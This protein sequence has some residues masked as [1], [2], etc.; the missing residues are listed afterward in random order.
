[1]MP[2][3]STI[4]RLQIQIMLPVTA[5]KITVIDSLKSPN[6]VPRACAL[7]SPSSLLLGFTLYQ[8][9][10][11]YQYW[12]FAHYSDLLWTDPAVQDS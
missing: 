4:T 6:I 2:F 1:M 12:L 5:T 11:T 3:I 8:P 7:V 10:F 9:L